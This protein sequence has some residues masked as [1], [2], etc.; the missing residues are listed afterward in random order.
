MMLTK[1][2][3]SEKNNYYGGRVG[4]GVSC[5]CPTPHTIAQRSMFK[6]GSQHMG[7][8]PEGLCKLVFF[9]GYQIFLY[10]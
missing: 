2:E 5:E 3:D 10:I 6:F 4:S 1:M 8:L 9:P 7:R